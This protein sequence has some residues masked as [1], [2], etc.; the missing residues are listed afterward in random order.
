[1]IRVLKLLSIFSLFSLYVDGQ[2]LA[3]A[4]STKIKITM[5]GLFQ[6]R[7]LFN[8]NKNIDLN[9]LH[10]TDGKATYN[11]FDIKRARLQFASKISDRTDVVLLLNLADF[12]SDPKNKVLENAYITY[13]LNSFLNAKMG[14]FRPAFGLED[15]YPVDVIKSMDYSNQYTAFGNNGWQSFQIGASIYGA[16]TGKLPV[17]YELSVVNGNNRNQA[18][19]NDNGKHF[20]SRVELGLDKKY[21]IKVGLNGGL[22]VVSGSGAYASGIDLSGTLPLAKKLSLEMETE[23]KQG[24]NHVLYYSIEEAKREG[25]LKKYQ[26]RGFYFLPNL[27]YAI[28]YHR[29]SSLEFSC[30][31][32]YFD[33]DFRHPGSKRE[34]WTPM[35][36]AEFLKAYSA[37]IQLGVNIDRYKQNI[38]G[39]TQYNN[40]TFI[41]QVQSR[42]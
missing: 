27:R 16:T 5:K 17:K 22:A 12:K 36:S 34:T 26:M 6:A 42:L 8:T 28:N 3:K 2:E 13:K 38:A 29:L 23:F 7:Y 19:D 9:G 32:E 40:S 14:Q 41:L 18:M 20:S 10:H 30:R 24:N 21:A 31:Y 39:T 1:M 37:R 11:D 35:L 15:M 25:N 33:K 4:D